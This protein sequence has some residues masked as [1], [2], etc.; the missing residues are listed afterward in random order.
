MSSKLNLKSVAC[1]G[2]GVIGAGWVARFIENGVNIK[3]YDISD[4]SR[5]ALDRTLT[6]AEIAYSNL[7]CLPRRHRGK[8]VFTTTI[9]E[10]VKG[11]DLIIES[12]PERTEIKRLAYEEIEKECDTD[13]L[14]A[15]STS[16]ILPSKLQKNMKRPERFFVG[17][18]FNPVYLLPLVEV[19]AGEKTSQKTLDKAMQVYKEIGMHPIYIKKEIEAFVADR[20]LEAIWRESRWLIKDGI[21]TTAELDDIVRFGFG[22]R[23][24]QMGVFDTYRVA[25]GEK[26][27]RH[28]LEQFGPCLKW[29]WTKLT[30]VPDFNDELIELISQ[31][32]D[33][34]SGHFSISEMEQ[35]RD[36]NLVSIQKA[37]KAHNWGAGQTLIDYEEQL[38]KMT[39]N[40]F[41]SDGHLYEGIRTLRRRAPSDWGDYNGH[42]NEARYLDC[43]CEAT[44]QFMQI[45]GCDEEYVRNGNSYFTV[46]T[47]IRHL[48]EVQIGQTVAVETMLVASEGKKMHLF[49]TM[50]NEEKEICATG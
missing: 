1:I 45:I 16:G 42:M 4:Q 23:Y 38:K 5:Q 13:T 8:A 22:L 6:N 41:R 43:F 10:A 24:A 26:G 40:D 17:H 31:Q 35:R 2:C 11:V 49:H 34:Q 7:T 3:I 46:E 50:L 21:C 14:I 48:K 44:D 12:I 27:M 19:V 9:S 39:L 36:A 28:F 20:L 29:P 37:L 32:S 33:N 47:H 25:G 18:P 30:N 15:S